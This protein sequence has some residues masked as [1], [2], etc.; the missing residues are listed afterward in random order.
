VSGRVRDLLVCTLLPLACGLATFPILEMGVNDDW[1]Y[2]YTARVL[3][4]TGQ[5]RY[6]GWAA[7]PLVPQAYLAA[8]VIRVFGFSFTAVRM[9][10]ILFAC[11]CGALLYDLGYRS[12]L[13]SNF[14][15]FGS[16]ALT[17]SPLTLPL[18][19]SFQSDI[20]GW[21]FCLACLYSALRAA[22][23]VTTRASGLWL[24]ATALAG[25]L[26]GATRQFYWPLPL[27]AI[28]IA[29]WLRRA[30]R[31]LL[32]AGAALWIATGL[33]C[34][35]T[36]RWFYA[37]P[38]VASPRSLLPLPPWP[39]LWSL[40]FNAVTRF[41]L[42]VLLVLLPLLA[43]YAFGGRRSP[44]FGV[45]L[46]GLPLFGLAGGVTFFE[47]WYWFPW[48]G[49]ILT[50]QGVLGT[51]TVIG[52]RPPV[53]SPVVCVLLSLAVLA[54]AGWVILNVISISDSWRTRPAPRGPAAFVLLFAPFCLAYIA[55]VILA[56][57]QGLLMDRYV[58]PWLPGLAIPL[59]WY[60][61]ESVQPR[62][63]VSA[64]VLVGIFAVYGV[65][66]THDYLAMSRAR[67]AAA[68][69]VEAAGVPRRE[70]AAGVEYD[71]WTQIEEQG[72]VLNRIR[73]DFHPAS[74]ERH[75]VPFYFWECT[76]AVQP[77]HFVV[78]SRHPRLRDTAFP[79]VA[80]ITWLPPSRR[81]VWIQTIP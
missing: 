68:S 51:E 33:A 43:L 38:L 66:T 73:K 79:P 22:G 3:A 71:G 25:I 46:A 76:P 62:I 72:Y 8:L 26:A 29:V 10:G 60:Y 9:V 78:V 37:Q 34:V 75:G 58:L 17:L 19:A 41:G 6:N 36:M 18:S 54:A 40:S 55:T 20:P 31:R 56:S 77:R 27:L 5:F 45:C 12:G 13:R 61:Q 7:M 59:L 11:G 16:L 48:M 80:Y 65:A 28:P 57:F 81:H 14:A 44:H 53:L 52:D 49:N 2:T 32:P 47:L 4:D 42:T 63:P 74:P 69:A 30:D 67:L 70:I 1:S 64:W 50:A 21:F 23:A 24:A 15:V 35:L 39:L